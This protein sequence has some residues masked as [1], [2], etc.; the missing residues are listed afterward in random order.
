MMRWDVL[1]K[2]I[3]DNNY[4]SLVEV[5]TARSNN[6]SKIL[7]SIPDLSVTCIDPYMQYSDYANDRNAEKKK[8]TENLRIA[9]KRVF[10]RD[11]V[12]HIRKTSRGA[13]RMFPDRSLELVFIDGNHRADYV[14]DDVQMWWPKIKP[15]GTLTGHDYKIKGNHKGVKEAVDRFAAIAMLELVIYQ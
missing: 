9:K 3:K 14:M 8:M 13:V 5:G 1:L 15:A 6:V 10:S 11:N 2:I 7:E 12:T 4:R